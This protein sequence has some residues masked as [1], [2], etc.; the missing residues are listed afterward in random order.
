MGTKWRKGV[1]CNRLHAASFDAAFTDAPLKD[2]AWRIA[3]NVAKLPELLKK[4]K[5]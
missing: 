4:T 5:E 1:R 2:E 3:V